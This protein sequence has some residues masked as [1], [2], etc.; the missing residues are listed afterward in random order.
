MDE[1]S[2]IS[3]LNRALEQAA[4]DGD[5]PRVGE[6]DEERTRLL[7]ALPLSDE[8]ALRAVVEDA[9]CVTQALLAHAVDARQSVMNELRGLHRGQRGASAYQQRP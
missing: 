7:V 4:A 9:L 1:L 5:W 3:T 6:I 2:R 8:P